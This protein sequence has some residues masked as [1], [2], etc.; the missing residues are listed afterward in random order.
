[1]ASGSHNSGLLQ[2]LEN[3]ANSIRDSMQQI[4][5][6]ASKPIIN[7]NNLADYSNNISTLN[8]PQTIGEITNTKNLLDELKILLQVE[9][10]RRR[11]EVELT[12]VESKGTERKMKKQERMEE[13]KMNLNPYVA[14][15]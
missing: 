15:R 6:Y 7:T 4:I 10:R 3:C 12:E 14:R 1:M 5:S 2:R 8:I 13:K 11:L 9:E